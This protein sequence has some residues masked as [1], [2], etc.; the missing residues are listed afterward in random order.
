MT[1]RLAAVAATLAALALGVPGAVAHPP[2]NPYDDTIFAPINDEV[3]FRV[4]LT[5]AAKGLTAPLK[6]VTAPGQPGR[7]YVVDQPG[8]LW[9]VDLTTGE[10]TVFLDVSARLVPLGVCGPGTF[11]E[12]GFLGVAFHPSYQTNGLLYTYTSEP[13]TGPPTFTSTVPPGI[14]PDHQNVVA[15]WRVPNPASPASVVDPA[16]RRE[17]LRVDWPQF[18]HDGGDVSFGPD[19]LLYISMGDGGAAD[20]EDNPQQLFVTAPPNYPPCGQTP[21]VGHQGDGNAQKLNTPLGKVLR[22]DVNG[23]NSA[24]HQYGI[25]ADNPFVMTPGALGEIYA[26]GLRNPFRFSFDTET[27]VL[28]LGEVGQNDIE[29][30][31]VIV[32][33][34]N[35]GWNRKEGTLFFHRNGSTVDMTGQTGFASPEPDPTVVIPPDLM[36]PIAQYDTHHE[37]HS[38]IGGFVYHGSRFPELDDRFVFGEFSRIF[39][40]PEGPDDHGRLLYI[41]PLKNKV[42]SPP[43][44]KI[45]E[46]RGFSEEIARLGL[47]AP[48]HTHAPGTSPQTMS[49]LGMAQDARGEVYVTG[50]KTGRPFG[51]DGFVLRIE[52]ARGR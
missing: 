8:R 51:T 14:A 27:G 40:F 19:E 52:H 33:G 9:A 28:Y 6:G 26:F 12:R 45:H 7:L 21:Q 35:Y 15:E 24:N 31:D 10:K 17:L 47:T 4:G 39:V 48:P 30:V 11:D 2:S 49:V 3:G 18:N 37:G 13:V 23:R 22:I 42:E 32:P 36:E 25:P 46:F 1:P 41:K 20:D 29:E 16:S 38:V 44:L 5:V 50:N 43:L 34:G